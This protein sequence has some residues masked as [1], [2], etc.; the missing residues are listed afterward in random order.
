M[1]DITAARMMVGA[2]TAKSIRGDDF[3][4]SPPEAVEA[5]CNVERF[6]GAIWEPAC[7][8]GA[9]SDVLAKRGYPVI[10]TDLAYRGYGDGGVDFLMEYAARAP[11]IVTNPPF[12][13]AEQFAEHALL[14]TGG[15]VAFLMRLVWLEGQR[16][17]NLF[18]RSPLARVWVFSRRIPRMHRHDYTGPTTTSTIAFAWFVWEH[19]HS[20][21]PELG[22][23]P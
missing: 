23:L 17:R 4:A 9:I 3:Y 13:L 14:L 11:N 20:G 12:K 15:K 2:R 7:G 21:R 16:R 22:W 1:S 6:D 8:T 18:V 19:G 10:S 5:L